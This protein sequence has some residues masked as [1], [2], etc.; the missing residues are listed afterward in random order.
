MKYISTVAPIYMDIHNPVYKIKYIF[1][2]EYIYSCAFHITLRKKNGEY[3]PKCISPVRIF[4][5]A[6]VFCE[7]GNVFLDIS[8][9]NSM[10]QMGKNIRKCER[11]SELCHSQF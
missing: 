11:I 1:P 2:T 8:W 7:F 10:F 6:N 4:H 3:F 9:N 5:V